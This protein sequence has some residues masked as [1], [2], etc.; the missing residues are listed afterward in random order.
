[1]F[2]V[3]DTLRQQL[4][5][6]TECWTF[7]CY[8]RDTRSC[9][10]SLSAFVVPTKIRALK[11]KHLPISLFFL[12]HRYQ[13]DKQ[14]RDYNFIQNNN[15]DDDNT[16]STATAGTE[17]TTRIIVVVVAIIVVNIFKKRKSRVNVRS[18]PDIYRTLISNFQDH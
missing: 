17:A 11:S 2:V 10:P 14:K 13:E 18:G 5:N 1:M 4:P 7:F 15:D 6:I 9:Y 8:Y 12:F 3:T 16:T